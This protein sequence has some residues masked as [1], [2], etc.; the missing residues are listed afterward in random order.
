MPERKIFVNQREPALLVKFE[1]TR[2]LNHVDLVACLLFLSL[3]TQVV[4]GRAAGFNRPSDIAKRLSFKA[5]AIATG[6]TVVGD[7]VEVLHLPIDNCLNLMDT[8]VI[9]FAHCNTLHHVARLEGIITG[10]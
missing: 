8:D 1:M 3:G 6:L 7:P 10:D 9:R 2:L 5:E 4:F